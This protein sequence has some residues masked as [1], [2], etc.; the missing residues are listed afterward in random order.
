MILVLLFMVALFLAY[1]NGANDNFKA[2]ATVYG[3]GVLS[4]RKALLLATAAQAT[5][6]AASLLLASALVKAFSGKG[7]VPDSAVS[8]PLFLTTV[9]IAAALT[10]LIATRAGLPVSTTHA[11]IGGLVGAGLIFAPSGLAWGALGTKY[12]MPLLISPVLALAGAAVLYPIARRLRC[13]LGIEAQ[14]CVCVEPGAELVP[15]APE[16][17]AVVQRAGALLTVSAEGACAGP[18]VGSVFG[19]SAQQIADSLHFCSAFSL[20]FA[21]GLNDTPKVFGLL[22]AAQLS[23]VEMRLALVCVAVV[24]AVGGL[25]HSRKLAETMGKR[26][27]P[28]NTGQGLLA[29]VVASALVIGASLLGSPVSTTHVSTGAIFGIGLSRRQANWPLVGGIVL[30]WVAT[31]PLGALLAYGTGAL[32]RGF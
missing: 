18:Y 7:L 14:S 15:A 2:T 3:A 32:L 28:L 5:G 30:A 19:V 6:S 8:N 26:I 17:A 27:T 22:V 10:V 11:L 21:R 25:L 1:A 9:G 31:L 20:G 12:F 29:N 24:M 13:A 4:Y 23:G 16:G